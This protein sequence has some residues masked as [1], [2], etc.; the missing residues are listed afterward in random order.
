VY[1]PT[2]PYL[3]TETFTYAFASVR[4]YGASREIPGEYTI[5][6]VARDVLALADEL[7]WQRFCVVGHSMGGMMAQKVACLAPERVT[8][9]VG[10]TPVPACG[11][12]FD[13]ATE[14]F[15]RGAKDQLTIRQQLLDNTTGNR[16]TQQFSKT[17]A[18]RSFEVTTPEV[19][20]AYLTAW[21][22]TDF[23]AEITGLETQAQVLVGQYD[24]AITEALITQTLMEWLPN[25]QLSVIENAGHYPT[26]EAPVATVTAMEAFL[27]A[28]ALQP[29]EALA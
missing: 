20:D 13:E 29:A 17:L 4:G 26:L 28:H 12:P 22:Q 10:I 6:E 21:S 23:T 18:Q 9:W 14:Q 3:D 16:L 7:G 15:F 19:F 5:E 1:E 25:I 27:K 24:P 11:Y 8:A 2:F